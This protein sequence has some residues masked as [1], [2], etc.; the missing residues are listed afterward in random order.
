MDQASWKGD[1]YDVELSY[2][3]IFYTWFTPQPELLIIINI[4]LI[5]PRSY[6]LYT[7]LCVCIFLRHSSISLE[8]LSV[9][10][11]FLI[12]RKYPK[13]FLNALR[14]HSYTLALIT[15]LFLKAHKPVFLN[16]FVFSKTFFLVSR[17]TFHFKEGKGLQ[18]KLNDVE[19]RIIELDAEQVCVLVFVPVKKVLICSKK[20]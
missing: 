16:Y 6:D 15:W 20:V 5:L 17:L 3:L 19:D 11:C 4:M 1:K 7:T 14:G 10:Y 13:L 9:L 2:S 12:L 8:V 18:R